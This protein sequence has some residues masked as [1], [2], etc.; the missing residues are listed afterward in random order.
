MWSLTKFSVVSATEK[1]QVTSSEAELD[2]Y[3]DPLRGKNTWWIK[4]KFLK[5]QKIVSLNFKLPTIKI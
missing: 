2:V 4:Y 5:Q 1:S 3:D